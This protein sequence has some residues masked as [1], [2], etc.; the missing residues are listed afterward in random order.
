M[1]LW[2]HLVP[3]AVITLNLLRQANKM[4]SVSAYEYVNGKFNYNKFLL[5][6]LG[7]TVEIHESTNRQNTWDPHSLS[8]WYLGTSTE[9]YRRH[10]IFCK[11]TRSE[12]ISDMVFFWHQYTTQPMVMKE[13]QIIKAV[14]D[15]SSALCHRVN[16]CVKEETAVLQKM[17]DTLNNTTTVLV[18]KKK[19]VT[20]KDPI[21]EP[22]VGQ[23]GGNLQQSPK[24]AQAPRVVTAT[25]DKP[26]CMVLTS[27]PTTCSKY[28]QAL[29][30]IVSRGRS[31]QS[32]PPLNMTELVHAA[33]D[34]DPTAAAKFVN[35][36]FDEESGK[37]LKY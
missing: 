7:C 6:P 29:A 10:K 20:F 4:P 31:T 1:S 16:L 14:G 23:S 2:D 32:Q 5:S 21:P 19:N 37:L 17:N 3:Q 22:R 34:D 8:G 33:I 28:T 15:P 26:L 18:E 9:H 36:V 24:T 30:N 13:D 12:R 35:E 11:K 25:I 27:G